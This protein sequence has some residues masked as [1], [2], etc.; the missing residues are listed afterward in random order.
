MPISTDTLERTSEDVDIREPKKFKVILHNDNVT[1]FQFVI[2]VLR[3]VF[4]KTYDE[5]LGVTERIHAQG[6]GIAGVYSREI[7][8]EK[9]IE[10]EK[11]ATKNGFP[12]QANYEEY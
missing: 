2:D 3:I 1:T 8:E 10:V 11:L 5:A 7:A 4:H 6:A 9:T 12:L